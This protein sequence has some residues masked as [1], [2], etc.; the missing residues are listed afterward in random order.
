MSQ[1]HIDG[2]DDGG[3]R[4]AAAGINLVTVV[5]VLLV[6]IALAWL[7][8]AGPLSGVLGGGTTNI[9]VNP[10]AQSQPNINVNPN[11]YVPPAGANPGAPAPA[12]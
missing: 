2:P 4:A 5:I 8:F 6:L 10:P 11:I 9:N 7:F 3:D 12:Q 1:I